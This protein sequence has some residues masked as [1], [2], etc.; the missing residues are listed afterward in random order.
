M[1]SS[2]VLPLPE[3]H[4][5]TKNVFVYVY[6]L[7][8]KNESDLTLNEKN[9]LV[10]LN[11]VYKY[12]VPQLLMW[13]NYFTKSNSSDT[14]KKAFYKFMKYAVRFYLS[15]ELRLTESEL[16]F[17]FTLQLPNGVNADQYN[18]TCIEHLTRK[19]L[20]YIKYKAK[21]E[22]LDDSVN[23]LIPEQYDNLYDF[24]EPAIAILYFPNTITKLELEAYDEQL[25][26]AHAK[27]D[28]ESKRAHNLSFFM[29]ILANMS[30]NNRIN[31]RPNVQFFSVVRYGQMI[32][33]FVIKK[34]KKKREKR[35]NRDENENSDSENENENEDEIKNTKS[36]KRSRASKP[37]L[38]GIKGPRTAVLNEREY[39]HM[40]EL[41][42]DISKYVAQLSSD[43]QKTLEHFTTFAKNQYLNAEE[44]YPKGHKKDLKKGQRVQEVF[45]KLQRK[46]PE[47]GRK[48]K[49]TIH[50]YKQQK[51]KIQA[52][53]Q[54][55]CHKTSLVKL[56][57]F[58][59]SHYP[60]R[61]P[62]VLRDPFGKVLKSDK[63][64]AVYRS[65]AN[66]DE[67]CKHIEYLKKNPD[68]Y[69]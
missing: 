63:D 29:S 39:N 11:V 48:V 66:R 23:E 51:D 65:K 17:H 32:D 58:V 5:A 15:S 9:I 33:K 57:A 22:D 52:E 13:L 3:K 4:Q 25:M 35:A 56:R 61:S 14:E 50:G 41:L 2:S 19:F 7:R 47:Q 31:N 42:H 8:S 34:D 53:I 28:E 44:F 46:K 37:K 55:N 64:E 67:L 1:A 20:E 18:T 6:K 27:V 59:A 30:S 49:H 60:N 45:E 68:N 24:I 40:L 26:S 54:H 12:S 36:R 38:A 69:Q 62:V 43:D 10:L 16:K 21:I